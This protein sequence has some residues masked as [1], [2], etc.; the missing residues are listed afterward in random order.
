MPAKFVRNADGR[1]NMNVRLQDISALE[2][3]TFNVRYTRKR[4]FSVR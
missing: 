1:L 4:T 2:I 3:Q